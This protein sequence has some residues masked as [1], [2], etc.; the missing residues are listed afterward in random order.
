MQGGAALS[1]NVSLVGPAAGP[2]V[3][4]DTAGLPLATPAVVPSS[5]PRPAVVLQL[6]RLA[7]MGLPLLMARRAD[8]AVADAAGA[9][10]AANTPELT[11]W[12]D[13]YVTLAIT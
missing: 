13:R 5:S 11:A 6:Q 4:L 8:V 12:R 1:Y 7:L 3:W 2:A 9:F 10:T